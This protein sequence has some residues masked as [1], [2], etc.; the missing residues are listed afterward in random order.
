MESRDL[1]IMDSPVQTNRILEVAYSLSS[2]LEDP[3]LADASTR[4]ESGALVGPS[5]WAYVPGSSREGRVAEFGTLVDGQ[6]NHGKR[7]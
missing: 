4:Q 7:M 5:Y 1:F 6:I 3:F 2:K